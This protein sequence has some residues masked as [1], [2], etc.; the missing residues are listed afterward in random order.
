MEKIYRRIPLKI[1][2]S[3]LI[4]PETNEGGTILLGVKQSIF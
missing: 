2:S 1:K 3:N 4:T